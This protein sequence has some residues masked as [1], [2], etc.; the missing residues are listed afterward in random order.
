MC[1]IL[2]RHS[3][4]AIDTMEKL[5]NL[6]SSISVGRAAWDEIAAMWQLIARGIVG[7]A[8]IVGT[9]LPKDLHLEDTTFY[10]SI[11]TDLGTR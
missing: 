1:T 2:D 4:A 3:L 10:H 6:R 8:P 5:M 7:Y 9:P 11:L